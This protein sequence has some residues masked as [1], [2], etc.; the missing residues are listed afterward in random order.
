MQ[1]Y[2]EKLSSVA[3]GEIAVGAVAELSPYATDQIT[4]EGGEYPA[5]PAAELRT[6]ATATASVAIKSKLVLRSS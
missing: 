6:E 3:A 2:Q 5:F 1:A 4:G